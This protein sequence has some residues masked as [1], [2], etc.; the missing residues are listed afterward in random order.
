MKAIS[1]SL[2]LFV[3]GFGHA[4]VAGADAPVLAVTYPIANSTIVETVTP[5]VQ[6]QAAVLNSGQTITSMSFLVCPGTGT[7]CTG[8]QMLPARRR[9]NRFR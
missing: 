6:L 2:A 1:S 4:L 8:I 5:T 7:T 9:Q 3:L